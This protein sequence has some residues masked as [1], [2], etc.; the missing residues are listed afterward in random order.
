MPYENYNA[1]TLP[2][3]SARSGTKKPVT[4]SLSPPSKDRRLQS[5]C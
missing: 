3:P 5:T 2:L 4:A 1:S